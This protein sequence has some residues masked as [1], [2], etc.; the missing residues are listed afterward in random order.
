MVLDGP[1]HANLGWLT[2]GTAVDPRRGLAPHAPKYVEAPA[3]KALRLHS[4]DQACRRVRALK[5]AGGQAGGVLGEGALPAPSRPIMRGQ[6]ET[7][8]RVADDFP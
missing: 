5:L 8:G 6:I 2:Q 7:S 1:T 3:R 4:S